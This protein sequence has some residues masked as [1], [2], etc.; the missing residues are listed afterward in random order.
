MNHHF[1]LKKEN[2]FIPNSKNARRG[3]WEQ[4]GF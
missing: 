3:H 1:L 2:R 4:S